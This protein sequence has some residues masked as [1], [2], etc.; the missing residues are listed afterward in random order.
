VLSAFLIDW[1]VFPR[2]IEPLKCRGSVGPVFDFQLGDLLEVAQI[3]SCKRRALPQSNTR[4]QQVA[5]TDFLE[6]LV[7]KELFELLARR[8]TDG[9][10]RQRCELPDRM[11]QSLLGPLQ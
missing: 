4:D 2:C 1:P 7:P 9:D 3:A 10:D 6:L 8:P 5:P 11:V